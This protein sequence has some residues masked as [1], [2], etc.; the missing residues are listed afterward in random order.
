MKNYIVGHLPP[1]IGGVSVYIYRLKKQFERNSIDID[2][3]D[4]SRLNW[5]SKIFSIIKIIF[6]PVSC[7]F[8]LNTSNY[9]FMIL[10]LCRPFKS[11]I[12]FFDHNYRFLENLTSF[13][14]RLLSLFFKRVNEF[15]VVEQKVIDYYKSN[16]IQ[17]PIN[18]TIKNAFI[19]PP[20]EDE[21]KIFN[22]YDDKVNLFLKRH[23]PLLIANAF[24]IEFYKNVDLY[25]L[26]FCIEVTNRLKT[27]F[28]DIGFVFAISDDKHN[29]LYIN[30]LM[31]RIQELDLE[32]NFIFLTGSKEIWP[33][34]KKTD[35]F[36]RPTSTD[37]DA[38]SIREAMYFGCPVIASDVC[39]R[40]EGTIYFKNREIDDLFE[41]CYTLLE[42]NNHH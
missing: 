37:G 13:Q 10:L 27:T 2:I 32:E 6:N 25:G 3:I 9:Y 12:N 22:T 14:K 38:I 31:N 16:Q 28:K 40:P 17:I 41:K 7:S 24:K 8:Y 33:L 19:A 30:Q 1:P 23:T 5:L 18:I 20:E 29:E 34:F 36:I 21:A 11:K 42:V 39:K 35:L 26:D 15:C 4:F